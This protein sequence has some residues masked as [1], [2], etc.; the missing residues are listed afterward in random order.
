MIQDLIIL[1][2]FYCLGITG[3]FIVGS[4]C[5]AVKSFITRN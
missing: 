3:L 5:D 4:I 1:F 2:C